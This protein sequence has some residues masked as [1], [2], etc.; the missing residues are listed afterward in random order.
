M[1]FASR[2]NPNILI[3]ILGFLMLA[4]PLLRG[5]AAEW[6]PVNSGLNT[7]LNGVCGVSDDN[8]VAVG[9]GGVILHYDGTGWEPML[10]G[11]MVDLHKC[12]ASSDTSFTAVGT[13]FAGAVTLTYDGNASGQWSPLATGIFDGGTSTWNNW[14]VRGRNAIRFDGTSW[15]QS[16]FKD[17][18]SVSYDA[19]SLLVDV[20]GV[21]GGPVVIPATTANLGKGG[22]F[23]NQDEAGAFESIFN[24]VRFHSAYGVAPDDIF[25]GGEDAVRRYQGGDILQTSNWT[26]MPAPLDVALSM[27]GLDANNMYAAGQMSLDLRGRIIHYDGN[28]SNLWTELLATFPVLNDIVGTASGNLYAV[29]DYGT[30]YIYADH[31]D[32]GTAV[33]VPTSGWA[34]NQV[35]AYSGEL[36]LEVED[37]N[38]GGVLPLYFSRYYASGL[39]RDGYV[40]SQMGNNWSHNFSWRMARGEDQGVETASVISPRGLVIR[41]RKNMSSGLWELVKPLDTPFALIQNTGNFAFIDPVEGLLYNFHLTSG[42]LFRIEDRNGNALIISQ[43]LNGV[44]R[45][46]SSSNGR[47]LDFQYDTQGRLQRIYTSAYSSTV[48]ANVTREIS[49]D[50]DPDGN[51][52]SKINFAGDTTSYLYDTTHAIQGLLTG[53]ILPELNQPWTWQY[54]SQ[55][56]VASQTDAKANTTSIF[57][58]SGT[59]PATVLNPLGRTRR[60]THNEEGQLVAETDEAG[61][62]SYMSYDAEGHRD[63]VTNRIGGMTQWV[64]D[65]AS[66]M[67]TTD[68]EPNGNTATTQYKQIALANGMV[69]HRPE[70]ITYQNGSFELYEY[71]PVGDLTAWQ[72]VTGERWTYTH[73]AQG[74]VTSVKPPGSAKSLIYTYIT[75]GIRGGLL[76]KID[77]GSGNTRTYGYDEWNRVTIILQPAATTGT[78]GTL[79]QN[80][81]YNDLDVVTSF[82]DENGITTDYTYDKNARLT[83]VTRPLQANPLR[84]EYDQM[85]LTKKVTDMGNGVI[86]PTHDALG[87]LTEIRDQ[88]NISWKI[89]HDP[90]GRPAR[91]LEGG[92]NEWKIEYT[93]EGVMSRITSP[94]G[95]EVVF[96]SSG[97]PMGRF[98]SISGGAFNSTQSFDGEGRVTGAISNG[99]IY[100]RT[101]DARG[102]VVGINMP[103]GVATAY[104]RNELGLVETATDPN[105]NDWTY[106]YD[107]LGGLTTMNDPLGNT[108]VWE[109]DA[110]RFLKSITL[111]GTFGVINNTYTPSGSFKQVAYPDGTTIDLTYDGLDRLKTINGVAL[112]YD[113]ASNIIENNDITAS[114]DAGNRLETLTLAPGRTITYQYHPDRDLLQ[115]ITDWTGL[116]ITFLYNKDGQLTD[117]VRSNGINTVKQYDMSSGLLSGIS[118]GAHSSI[119][120]TRNQEGLIKS[121]ARN[122]PNPASVSPGISRSYTFDAASQVSTFVHDELGR[123]LNDGLRTLIWD[124]ASRLQEVTLSGTTVSYTYDGFNMP[125]SRTEGGVTTEY[126]WN[127]ILE[128]PSISILSRGGLD[129]FYYVHTPDGRLLYAITPG[130]NRFYYHY[131]QAGNTLFLTNDAGA[132]VATYAYSPY[133]EVLSESGSVENPFTFDGENGVLRDVTTGLYNMRRRWYDPENARFVSREPEPDFSPVRLNPYTYARG[134]PVRYSDPTGRKDEEN[135]SWLAKLGGALTI[136]QEGL[137]RGADYLYDKAQKL[138]SRATRYAVRSLHNSEL[139]GGLLEDA[140]KVPSGSNPHAGGFG[141]NMRISGDD[142]IT[143]RT[144]RTLA[145]QAARNSSRLNTASKITGG[146]GAALAGATD[147]RSMYRTAAGEFIGSVGVGLVNFFTGLTGAGTAAGLADAGSDIAG[148]PL[149]IT[150]VFSNAWRVLVVPTEDLV[151]DGTPTGESSRRWVKQ[152]KRSGSVPRGVAETG[153]SALSRQFARLFFGQSALEEREKE[154]KEQA[155]R[156]RMDRV[157]RMSIEEIQAEARAQ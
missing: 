53:Y 65:P 32:P 46:Q 119:S 85:G 66:G 102:Q 18:L 26:T 110:R 69:L 121:E 84:F 95:R 41:F 86:T 30:I 68:T 48:G 98:S 28:T 16:T 49:Y 11:T 25:V 22:I 109:Y 34:T 90:A 7:N 6:L 24:G 80:Y 142:A 100:S 116:S 89:R 153:E 62:T 67:V 4:M 130:G 83:Q 51:L 140:S 151:V 94:E 75:G 122:I 92:V 44:T 117:I 21:A 103:E 58:S 104:Q 73:N 97:N 57:L 112:D 131:D 33:N 129:L 141:R 76:W 77:D 82:T 107:E 36:V 43:G 154:L 55:G 47:I 3:A 115:N 96:D 152:I 29:G 27:W 135:D 139:I 120:I 93:A 61:N 124:D 74:Q 2:T 148:K 133:G 79:T 54:D 136:V 39:D 144:T 113:Y 12:Y 126:A 157:N 52:T 155:F 137:G 31:P 101:P 88:N 71:N 59:T 1:K 70:R 132:V 138:S 9:D 106:D 17:F 156:I 91:Y 147:D 10:S 50:Y 35:N 114:H 99:K 15:L 145:D 143:S 19:H 23:V 14:I 20:G 87:R 81:S 72:D 128:M 45:V 134:N 111:P 118:E 78:T 60:L 13:S 8:M 56:R 149:G 40:S 150:Q 63:T 127:N 64:F 42:L 123:L 125:V 108:T 146:I 37:M 105:M 5:Y 38:L